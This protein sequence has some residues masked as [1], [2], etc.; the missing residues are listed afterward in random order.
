MV[1][2]RPTLPGDT[3][4]I[5]G[6]LRAPEVAEFDALG[7]TSED[8][9]RLGLSMSEASTFFIE[10][11]PAGMFGVADFGDYHVPWGVF[12]T[13]IDRKPIAFLRFAKRWMK[14][15]KRPAVN[16]VDIRNERAVRW[17]GW[18]GFEVSQP[19]PY[20]MKG[21]LFRQVSMP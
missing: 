15:M 16:Y 12:T 13:A 6:S 17:F 11:E 3:W 8:C 1:S 9:M 14:N 19:V 5:L 7:V 10:G 21:E 2:V 18:L 4:L 20:G